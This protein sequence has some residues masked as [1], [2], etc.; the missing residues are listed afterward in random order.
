[1]RK[2]IMFWALITFGYSILEIVN[3]ESRSLEA[4]FS[5][6]SLGFYMLL[7]IPLTLLLMEDKYKLDRFLLVWGILSLV[8]S[9]KGIIQV[10]GWGLDQWEQQWLNE[11]NYKTHVLFG[12][13]RAFSFLSDAGQF[14]A[15][16]AYSAVV[17]L[18]TAFATGG[19]KRKLF[20]L[21]VGLVALYGMVISGTRGAI[22]IP[23]AGFTLYFLLRR[24]KWL[25]VSGSV[26][27]AVII[28]F[29]KFTTIGQGNAEIRR[30][31]TA[32]DPNDASLQVRINN[33][34]VLK[35]YLASRPFG[36]GI[37]HGGVKAQRFLPNAYLSQIPTDSWYVLIWVEQGIVG[38]MLHIIMLLYILIRSCYL[39]MYRIKDPELKLKLSA[40]A[41]GLFGVMIASYGNAILG[42]MPTNVL[43]F[44][45]M[46]VLLNAPAIDRPN[47]ININ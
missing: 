46:A 45:S 33:Q 30:M 12:K 22:S 32:F 27:L 14:G 10:K 24:N 2:D 47:K 17:M 26:I 5:G 8:A 41:A 28:F 11:G 34:K 43:I 7:L 3:P 4:W 44:I 42:Q 18:I 23:F 25:L 13:L 21:I 6:R 1:M 29:F 35:N 15:I 38:L 39:I 40:L 37:G 9:I 16:Q 31:R 20:F 36:G 19:W